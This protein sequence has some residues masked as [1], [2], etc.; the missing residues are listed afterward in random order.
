MNAT[1]IARARLTLKLFSAPAKSTRSNSKIPRAKT[2][3]ELGTVSVGQFAKFRE[4]LGGLGAEVDQ[5]L[6]VLV[7]D[8]AGIGENSFARGAV[9]Q[10]FAELVFELA[11]GLADGRLGAEK[12]VGSA[13]E[14]AL[15]SYGKED[16]QLRKLHR[17]PLIKPTITIRISNSIT[18]YDG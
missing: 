17:C 16:F 14:P 10:G 11:D 7:Q 12:L 1:P 4:R 15:A 18:L 9:E 3:R 6:G 8:L 5:L 2:E 13:G